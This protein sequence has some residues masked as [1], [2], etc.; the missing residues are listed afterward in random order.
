MSARTENTGDG[1]IRVAIDAPDSITQ[2]GVASFLRQ[3]KRLCV[4]ADEAA[5]TDVTVAVREN[6]DAATLE[7]LRMPGNCPTPRFLLVFEKSWNVD[8][9]VAVAR[10]VRAVLSRADCSPAALSDAL[11]SLAAG[12]GA[13]PGPL[14]GRLLDLVQCTCGEVRAEGEIPTGPGAAPPALLDRREADILRWLADGLNLAEVSR[15]VS[16]SERTIKNVLIQNKVTDYKFDNL[17]VASLKG[18][19]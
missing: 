17:N 15:K 5:D 13:L 18:L 4:V 11:V 10:G 1:D 8:V 7:G 12:G 3:D 16:Y 14:L 19:L 2:A 9:A 6:V